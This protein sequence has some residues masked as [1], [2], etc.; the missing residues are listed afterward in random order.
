MAVKHLPTEEV[1]KGIK[2]GTTGC[3]FNTNE[4]PS[5]WATTYEKI[6]CIKNGCKN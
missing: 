1:H 4:I 2:G 3:G 6:T 5:H